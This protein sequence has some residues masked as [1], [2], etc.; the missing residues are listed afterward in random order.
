MCKG[1][2]DR[3]ERKETIKKVIIMDSYNSID[4]LINQVRAGGF[5]AEVLLFANADDLQSG[6]PYR[7]L[8]QKKFGKD[9]MNYLLHINWHPHDGT[10]TLDKV[11]A[12]LRKELFIPDKEIAGIS[13]RQIDEAMSRVSWNERNYFGAAFLNRE[14]DDLILMSLQSQIFAIGNSLRH[15]AYFGQ[16]EGTDMYNRLLYKH[17][18]YTPNENSFDLGEAKNKY[19][20]SHSFD[21]NTKLSATAQE[22]YN[23]LD[24]RSVYKPILDGKGQLVMEGYMAMI[25]SLNG[26]AIK[27]LAGDAVIRDEFLEALLLK[28]TTDLKTGEDLIRSLDKGNEAEI[29]IYENGI[30]VKNCLVAIDAL[31]GKLKVRDAQEGPM[32][33]AFLNRL[34]AFIKSMERIGFPESGKYIRRDVANG[35]R[36]LDLQRLVHKDGDRFFYSLKAIFNKPSRS[37]QE[38]QLTATM[39]SQIN[40][41]REVL[42]GV[43]ILTLDLR[44]KAILWDTKD[45]WQMGFSDHSPYPGLETNNQKWADLIL[46][47]LDKLVASDSPKGRWAAEGLIEKYFRFTP[48][49]YFFM[50]NDHLKERFEIAASIDLAEYPTLTVQ[51]VDNLLAGRHVFEKIDDGGEDWLRLKKQGTGYVVDRQNIVLYHNWERISV[52]LLQSLGQKYARDAR[53]ADR[54]NAQLRSGDIAE[55]PL[56][57]NGYT[58]F[59]GLQADP[60][61]REPRLVPIGMASLEGISLPGYFEKLPIYTGMTLPPVGQCRDYQ[62]FPISFNQANF[63]ENVQRLEW[64]GLGTPFQEP[65]KIGMQV[66]YPSFSIPVFG[67]EGALGINGHL[68]FLSEDNREY[69]LHDFTVEILDQRGLVGEKQT[70]YTYAGYADNEKFNFL[71]ACNLMRGRFVCHV[72]DSGNQT[73]EEW[74]YL[75]RS[76]RMEDGNYAVKACFSD[77][78]MEKFLSDLRLYEKAEG[79][80]VDTVLQSLRRGDIVEIKNTG[81]AGPETFLISINPLK[82]GVLKHE[83][84]EWGRVMI[85]TPQEYKKAFEHL[86]PLRGQTR[87]NM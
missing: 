1:A 78:N 12:A 51:K 13:L 41:P 61:R 19:E 8:E 56:K 39:I 58:L 6:N 36:E 77:F 32:D 29:P 49:E 70:F 22:M 74:F 47:E 68:N 20:I 40:M 60:F 57:I 33:E 59:I 53:L 84:H 73:R 37:F 23:L 28:N 85:L 64:A 75:D 44:M 38:G 18:A 46:M 83:E 35:H 67:S 31:Q 4:R 10:Y 79:L 82:G 48:N 81:V 55:L 17:I 11:H 9:D 16:A 62:L 42:D 2:G 63:A 14:M 66:A 26:L 43:D 52:N 76:H 34:E 30:V 3:E 21:L 7:C 65:L 86:E 71:E 27:W 24:G 25:P 15:L 50:G 72:V 69:D 45:F 54:V 80:R 5:S 87:R